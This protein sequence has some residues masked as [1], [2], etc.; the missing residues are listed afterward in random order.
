L[1]FT[2]IELMVVMGI[3]ILIVG[4][5]APGI[6]GMKKSRNIVAAGYAISGLLEQARMYAMANNTYVWVG[7][8]EEDGTRSSQVPAV[9]GNGG[10]LVMAAVA[11]QS[12]E[13]YQDVASP[14]SFGLG[15]GSNPVNLVLISRLIKIDNV[16]LSGA[17]TSS[18]TSN[19]PRRPVV[20]NGCQVG[21]SSLQVP[22]NSAG[23]FASS[24]CFT[25]PL[26]G[27]GNSAVAQYT[28]AKVIEFDPQ[29]EASKIGENTTNG[30]GIPGMM[31]VAL[32]PMQGG[33]LDSRYSGAN[34]NKAA[35]AVQIEGFSGQVRIYL[36]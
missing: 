19:N 33:M 30:S 18:V 15:D 11:S 35:V 8:F 1:G 14:A 21:D 31:E 7:F 32:V 24:I 23:N 16:R 10:R 12:G 29:G 3:M 36:P 4:L 26:G 34:T 27:A 6:V 2:L 25:F 22:K 13:R 20:S 9:V 28:F 5:S 17:N